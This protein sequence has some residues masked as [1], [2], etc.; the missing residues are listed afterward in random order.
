MIHNEEPATSNTD[1][2]EETGQWT[3]NFERLV[4]LLAE[5]LYQDASDV[6]RELL[7]NASDALSRRNSD[8]LTLRHMMLY[9]PG[10]CN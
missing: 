2:A 10:Y 4:K 7:T 1:A 8:E 9:A 6:I 5:K 3:V